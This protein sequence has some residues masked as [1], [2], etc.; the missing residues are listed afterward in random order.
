MTTSMLKQISI[1]GLFGAIGRAM[2]QA[3]SFSD[4]LAFYG[5]Y[6]QDPVNQAIHFV[7][8][9][10]IWWS[11]CVF[12]AYVDLPG[13]ANLKVAGHR[14]SW[15]TAM[16]ALYCAFYL[17]LDA[18]CG[19]IFSLVLLAMYVSATRAVEKER[20]AGNKHHGRKMYEIAFVLHALAWYAQIHPG[21]AIFEQVKPAL[22]DSLGQSFGVAPLF[23]F[24]EGL[25][26]VGIAPE[27]HQEVLLAV[28]ERRA[29]MCVSDPA[30]AFCN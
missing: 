13:C 5:S 20:A 14:V 17:K 19:G 1:I 27:L 22:L 10:T 12:L 11:I 3:K 2:I 15:A 26:A 24:L 28:S 25:W 7:F 30:L 8:V 6:H 29:E 16:V 21:H 18:Y 4:E 23:A 9:P